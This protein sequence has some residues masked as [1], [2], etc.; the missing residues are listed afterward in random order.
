MLGG[1]LSFDIVRNTETGESV[2]DNFRISGLVTH[3]GYNMSRIRVYPL[4]EYDDEVAEVHG[5]KDKTPEFSV[6]YLNN[7]LSSIID[8]QF[9]K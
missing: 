3:Y 6:K 8:K 5:V 9:L 1:L 2:F 7:M 4:S